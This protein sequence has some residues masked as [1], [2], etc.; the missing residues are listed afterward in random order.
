MK[1][2]TNPS[3]V[4]LVIVSQT[5]THKHTDKPTPVK[6]YSLAFGGVNNTEKPSCLREFQS[7]TLI[8]PDINYPTGPGFKPI[9]SV[10]ART[11][12]T[13][14]RNGPQ[15]IRKRPQQIAMELDQSTMD[16]A[17]VES[18]SVVIHCGR[19]RVR[20]GF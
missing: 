3:T 15:R 16:S 20:C 6:T 18:N 8:I 19:F 9:R 10:T 4:F 13:N 5:H 14:N 1:F 7:F 17:V 2:G 11:G 12:M